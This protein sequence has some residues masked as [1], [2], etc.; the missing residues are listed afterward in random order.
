MEPTNF[1]NHSKRNL[2]V[3]SA[4]LALVLFGAVEAK[5]STQIFGFKIRPEVIPTVLF[6]VV[7]Y[8]LYQFVLAQ[9]FQADE[10]RQKVRQDFGITVTFCGVVLVGYVV[11]Y[12]G[13]QILGFGLWIAFAVPIAILAAAI[14]FVLGRGAVWIKWRRE[15]IELR[16]A[17]V[18]KR[19]R[20][21]GWVL[22]YNPKA[23][24]RTKPISF[25]DDGTIGEG[26]NANEDRWCL[27]GNKLEMINS[28]GAKQNEFIYEPSL[29]QFKSAGHS[30][31]HKI[32]GQYI[33]R[34][35]A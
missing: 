15:A 31:A 30:T 32:E 10:V 6:F 24:G 16:E 7:V 18:A 17:T 25:N 13:H 4:V 12:L 34:P 14:A 27:T 1:Y 23:P 26:R 29:D 8:L 2:V 20:E 33:F 19:L 21:P 22:N 5:D 9:T 35:S 11:F 3:F 28:E